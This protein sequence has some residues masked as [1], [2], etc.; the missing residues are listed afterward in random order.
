MVLISAYTFHSSDDVADTNTSDTRALS[1]IPAM[2]STF[3]YHFDT[4]TYK[5]IS[6]VPTNLFINGK[7]VEPVE[8]GTIEYV[9]ITTVLCLTHVPLTSKCAE[10]GWV[11]QLFTLN[12]L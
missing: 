7:F 12:H 2:S 9:L 5:G 11:N 6:T 10:S 8:K 4:P 1:S 3:T